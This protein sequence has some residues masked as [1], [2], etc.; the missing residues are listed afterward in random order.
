MTLDLKLILSLGTPLEQGLLI[1]AL[2]LWMSIFLTTSVELGPLGLWLHCGRGNCCCCCL[3]ADVFV[4]AMIGP[5]VS[6][7][8]DV[9]DCCCC[10]YCCCCFLWVLLSLL[11]AFVCSYCFLIFFFS[12]FYLHLHFLY[13][14][15][16]YL[17][18]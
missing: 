4:V 11:S 17:C 12:S 6:T 9:V 7:A 8:S 1:L 16:C 10:C 13:H 15:S 3:W 2:R 14:S 5:M 18:S